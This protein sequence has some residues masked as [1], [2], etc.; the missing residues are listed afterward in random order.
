MLRAVASST[1]ATRAFFD[2]LEDDERR[3][4]LELGVQRTLPAGVALCHQRQVAQRTF[5]ILSGRVKVAAV[6]EDGREAVLAVRGP[7]E[8]IGELAALD[9][10]PYSATVVSLEPVD[11][12]VV[13]AAGFASFVSAHAGIARVL[14]DMLAERL[15]EADHKL[16][17]FVR[18]DT[19]G[20][21]TARILQL[22]ERYGESGASGDIEIDLPLTQ[23]ELAGWTGASRE[24][25]GKALATLRDCGWIETGRKRLVVHDVAALQRLVG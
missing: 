2:R 11:V 25:V 22:V 15:R 20:R 24:A 9:G 1:S 8:L 17:E 3:A 23:E 5:V 18:F 7:G 16:A 13:P 6:T 10:Q 21:V 14:L 12:L 4:L 19:L